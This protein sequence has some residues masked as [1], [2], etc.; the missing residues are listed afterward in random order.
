MTGTWSDFQTEGSKPRPRDKLQAVAIGTNIYYFGGFGPKTD[1]AD[2]SSDCSPSEHYLLFFDEIKSLLFS[3][4]TLLKER[5]HI[6]IIFEDSM[7]FIFRDISL[8]QILCISNFS[9]INY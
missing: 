8:K 2:V 4:L 5:L 1:G 7:V 6:R 9:K 3:V